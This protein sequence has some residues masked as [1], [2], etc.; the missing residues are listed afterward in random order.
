MA[1]S[2]YEKIVYQINNLIKQED[3]YPK[4][5]DSI[6]SGKNDYKISQVYTRKNYD[7]S[8]IGTI[9]DCIVSLDNIVRNPRKF[10]VIEEDIVDISLA[11]SISVESVKHLS[12]HT[13]L[14]SS[15]DKNGMVIPS[16]ILNT[17]KEESFDIYENRFIYTLLLKVRDFID[18]RF[19]E[20]QNALLRSGE[21]DISVESEFSIDRNKVKYKLDGAANFPFDAVVKKKGEGLTDVERVTHIKSIISDFL[22]SPFSREM[23]TC[24]LVRPPILRTNVILKNPDFK[25]ALVLWQFIES[26]E[27]MDFTIDSVTETQEMAPALADKYRGLIFLNTILMQSIANTRTNEEVFD[28]QEEVKTEADEYRTKNIDDFVPDDFPHLKMELSEIRR[29]YR[30]LIIGE[31]TL[32]SGE[33]SKLNGA[34]DRVIRQYKINRAKEDSYRQQQLILKQLEEEKIAKRLALREQKD[35]ERKARAEEARR[36]IQLRKDEAEHKLRMRK[37]EAQAKME[38]KRKEKEARQKIKDEQERQK[39][40][41]ARLEQERIELENNRL[42]LKG[43][44]LELREIQNKRIQEERRISAQQDESIRLLHEEFSIKE[45]IARDKLYYAKQQYD[46]AI[47]RFNEEEKALEE[48]RRAHVNQ[49][50]EAKS[51]RVKKEEEAKSLERLA[52]EKELSAKQVDEQKVATLQQMREDSDKYWEEQQRLATDLAIR[53]K[54]DVLRKHENEQTKA[55]VGMREEALRAIR[56]IEAGFNARLTV[57]EMLT[58]EALMAI[59]TKNMSEEELL[60]KMREFDK[61]LRKRSRKRTFNRIKERFSKKK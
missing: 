53:S 1:D 17:S 20:I 8:W 18:R 52:Q 16:K 42:A 37:L 29:V 40:E 48:E 61:N 11:R 6:S 41:L 24:A 3:I 33:M 34:L 58:V 19:T 30:R 44:L 28:K 46:I 55:I 39:A 22:A 54:L 38:E 7:N 13:N 25:K 4:Y 47:R 45:G 43:R 51:E 12:Q 49:M 31:P 60:E 35:L 15:V 5:M 14:I 9:E 27:K 56:G 23:R 57:E 26:V 10:I 2:I 59:A 32:T 36:R 21:I 50:A